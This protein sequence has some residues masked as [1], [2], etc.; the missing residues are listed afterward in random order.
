MNSLFVRSAEPLRLCS[1]VWCRGQCQYYTDQLPDRAGG[2]CVGWGDLGCGALALHGATSP[3]F[4]FTCKYCPSWCRPPS[5]T[6]LDSVLSRD[7]RQNSI[8]LHSWPLLC[9]YH[10]S[11]LVSPSLYST[12]MC[13]WG[14]TVP[15]W[16]CYQ[17]DVVCKGLSKSI[18]LT[19]LWTVLCTGDYGTPS[20]TIP[21]FSNAVFT[22]Y[23][24]L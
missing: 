7:T 19:E 8:S 9:C 13:W 20:H 1:L 6:V 21:T 2:V 12:R 18:P 24:R 5:S 15:C 17:T 10:Q 22:A 3:C 16:C 11:G 4:I 23:E 14:L